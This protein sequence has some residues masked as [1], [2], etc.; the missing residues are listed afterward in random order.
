[1]PERI[2]FVVRCRTLPVAEC[3][4][5][6]TER[7]NLLAGPVRALTAPAVEMCLA[8]PSRRDPVLAVVDNVPM[9]AHRV[10]PPPSPGLLNDRRW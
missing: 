4:L 8:W 9:A 2:R 6:V 7:D 1:M 3:R 5:L 10:C